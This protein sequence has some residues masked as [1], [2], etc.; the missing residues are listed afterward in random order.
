VPRSSILLRPVLAAALLLLLAA[1]VPLAQAQQQPAALVS[2]V[3]VAQPLQQLPIDVR[4]PGHNGLA[5]VVLYDA[6]GRFAGSASGE[7]AGGAGTVVV[8]P[9]GALGPQ[10]AA[11][12]VDGFLVAENGNLFRLDAQNTMVTGLERFDAFKPMVQT[13]LLSDTLTYELDGR[14][15]HGYR[16]PDSPLIWLRDHVYQGRGFRYSEREVRSALDAFQRAQ[17]EDGSL[18]DYL[19]RP[20]FQ[21]PAWRTPVEADVEFLYVQ[22]VYEAWQMHGDDAWLRQHLPSMRKALNYTLRDPLRWDGA[23]G[24]VRR[25]FTIDTWDFE[26]GPTTRDPSNG[27]PAPRHWIDEA[28]IWGT[29]HGDNTGLAHALELMARAEERVGDANLAAA[30]REIG[31]GIMQR[32]NALSWNGRFFLHHVPERPFDVPGVDEAEQLSLS[33]ALALNRGVLSLEQRQAIVAEYLARLERTPAFA[34]WFSIDPPFPAG[35]Y[36][37]AGRNGELP[38]EYV[39]GGIMPLVGGE[40]ARG[41]FGAGYESYGFNIL[42]R[43]WLRMLSKGRSFLWYS[44]N[45]AEGVGTDAT[46]HTDGWGATAM[47]GA[48]VE[49]AAGIEDTGAVY[50]ELTIS[51]RWPAAGDVQEAYVVARYAAS[52]GYAAYR[53]Q[54]GYDGLSLQLSSSAERATVRLLLPPDSRQVVQV[55]RDGSPAD[56]TIEQVFNSRYVVVAV[57]GGVADIQ[58]TLAQ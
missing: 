3:A 11:L 33:N 1:A 54:G 16:S 49:G 12:F 14:M 34:E 7:L 4:V 30:W 53:W 21:I 29:F 37:L 22:G 43:Y 41:A 2:P 15:V 35:A 45:G 56:Y 18:P 58:V 9:R 24:L 52:D 55:L 36:G 28:T 26:Y 19:A 5:T 17:Y 51:P 46:L 38:G 6:A 25:P 57:E 44:P 10:W 42:E 39:N 47:L 23:R 48:L 40:L 50:R 32:L 8:T 20:E 27:E 31:S 13:L